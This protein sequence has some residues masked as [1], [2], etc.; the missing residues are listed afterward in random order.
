MI[1]EA[2]LFL[3]FFFSGFARID[4]TKIYGVQIFVVISI[5]YI[6]YSYIFGNIIIGIENETTT[7]KNYKRFLLWSVPAFLIGFY[8]NPFDASYFYA[9]TVIP[10]LLYEK[11]LREE[12]NLKKL[13]VWAEISLVIVVCLGWGIRLEFLSLD[14]LYD[15]VMQ[16]EFDLGYWGIS[17]FESSRNHDYM[18]PMVCAAISLYQIVNSDDWRIKLMQTLIFVLCEITLLA[19]FARGAMLI[20]F[21]YLL[22]L[23]L[24]LNRRGRI[25]ILTLMILTVGLF[26]GVLVRQ[27][28]DFYSNI[29]LSIFGLSEKT[30]Y[31]GNF[32]NELRKV[33][34]LDAISAAIKNPIGYGV[35]NFSVTSRINGGSAENA[36]LTVAVERGW[37]ACYYF[38]MFLWSKWKSLRSGISNKSICFFLLPS[39]FLYFMFNYEFTSYMCVFVFYLILISDK[40]ESFCRN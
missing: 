12:I 39:L 16:T 35:Q 1:K 7:A 34:Y 31:G 4:I 22:L 19:S 26:W 15:D 25:T 36:F 10:L 29:F 40:E 9:Y 13:L 30:H 3:M 23:Y 18:Y 28:Q 11:T 2:L 6:V 27:T 38:I 24:N 32:S 33:I 14:F 21:I 5:L 17:Y 20:S 8:Y 37:F